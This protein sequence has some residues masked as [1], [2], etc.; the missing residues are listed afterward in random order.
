MVENMIAWRIYV[1]TGRAHRSSR[2]MH[3]KYIPVTQ[4]LSTASFIIARSSGAVLARIN[5][6]AR[7]IIDKVI[8]GNNEVLSLADRL[9]SHFPT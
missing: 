7:S 1:A 8:R 4:Q 3:G 5:T 2:A 9:V 6:D